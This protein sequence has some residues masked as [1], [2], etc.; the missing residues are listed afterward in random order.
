M[1]MAKFRLVLMIGM[2]VVLSGCGSSSSQSEEAAPV[3]KLSPSEIDDWMYDENG[4]P[5]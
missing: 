2:V 4:L 3:A 5:H 1:F